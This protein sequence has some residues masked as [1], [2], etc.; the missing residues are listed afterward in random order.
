MK[1]IACILSLILFLFL[2]TIS[3][4]ADPHGLPSDRQRAINITV[5][6]STDIQVLTPS[7]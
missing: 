7:E 4:F 5:T 2:G 1:R 3:V 6:E